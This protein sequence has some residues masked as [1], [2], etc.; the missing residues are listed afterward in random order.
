MHTLALNCGKYKFPGPERC[1]TE[2]FGL[3]SGLG[4]ES[5]KGAAENSED[6][7]KMIDISF[8]SVMIMMLLLQHFVEDKLLVPEPHGA[9]PGKAS[10]HR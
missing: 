5:R 3:R 9:R 6:L 10:T 7:E 4:E 1:E 2:G 8:V